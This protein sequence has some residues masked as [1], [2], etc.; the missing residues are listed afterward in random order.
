M[1]KYRKKIEKPVVPGTVTCPVYKKTFDIDNILCICPCCGM[2]HEESCYD[3]SLP[4]GHKNDPV[5]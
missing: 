4:E 2:V 1:S 3:F 5:G